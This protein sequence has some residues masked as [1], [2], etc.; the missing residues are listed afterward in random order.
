MP[1]GG[2]K[3]YARPS[4]ASSY[5]VPS[6]SICLAP[7][8][9]AE[10]ALLRAVDALDEP[11]GYCID[12]PGSGPTLDLD[13]PLQGHTCKFRD[14]IADQLFDAAAG[15]HIR[16]SEYD[17]CLAVEA[18]EPGQPLLLRAL[19]RLAA[20]TLAAHERPLE[21]GCAARAL[22]R[23]RRRTRRALGHAARS[24]TPVY[25]RQTLALAACDEAAAKL[26]TFRWLPLAELVSSRA[27]NVRAGMPPDVAAAL[28]AFGREFDGA[29]AQQTAA[30]YAT[31]PRVYEPGEIA[32]DEG[33]CVRPA[34]APASRYPHARDAGRPTRCR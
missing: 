20:P 1:N 12:I 17:R 22:R 32:V 29:I 26:Q 21:P 10:P 13:A 30:I 15:Q 4:A 14:A 6:S 24:I 33:P 8:A 16:A 5:S 25:R 28:A 2:R 34:R 11:R 27:D 9:A 7:L 19:R 18:L 3:A 31:Q 23:A